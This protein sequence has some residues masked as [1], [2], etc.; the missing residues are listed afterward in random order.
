MNIKLTRYRDGW[1]RLLEYTFGLLIIGSF[2]LVPAQL[3]GQGQT[4]SGQV[5]SAD[6]G[7]VLPGVNVIVKGTNTGTS[8]DVDGQYELTV[9]SLNDTL[10]VSFVG[11]ETLEISISG[12]TEVNIEMQPQAVV[13]DEMVVIG[14]GK[15]RRS[16]VIG[17]IGSVSEQSIEQS[18][19]IVSP[20]Q[21][22]QGRI[23]GV[24]VMSSSGIP[25]QGLRI[26]IR[27]AASVSGSNEPLYVIDGV[28]INGETDSRF[29]FGIPRES[30]IAHL[31]SSDIESIE[32][33]K[34]ASA[35]AIYG[36]RATNGVVLIT[37]K[38]GSAGPTQINLSSKVGFQREPKRVDIASSDDYFEIMNKARENYNEDN[39]LALGDPGYEPPLEDPRESGE[40]DT[41]WFDLVT[42][43]NPV[44]RNFNI[45]VSGGDEKTSF[46]VSGDYMKNEG[47]IKT[48]QID[49]FSGRLNVDHQA[50]KRL[51]LNLSIGLS[52]TENNRV[53]NE[54]SGRGI[55][56]R[57]LEQ[58]PFDDPY[59]GDGSYQI[60]GVDILRHNGVQVINEQD[61]S[62]KTDDVTFNASGIFEFTE[63]L[64]YEA[65]LGGEL[66]LAHEY[67]YLNE[68]H[69]RGGS[70]GVVHDWR[71]IRRDF[72]LENM[73]RFDQDVR[74]KLNISGLLGYSMQ[75]FVHEPSRVSGED[76]PSPSFGYI[77]SAGRVSDGWTSWNSYA[78]ESWISRVNLNYDERYILSATLRRDGSSKFMDENR[79]GIFPSFSGGWR[80]AQEPFFRDSEFVS[81][82]RLRL[83]YGLT[84][85]QAGIGDYAAIPRAGAG[86]N[87]GG[88]T[89]M[90]IT[91]PGNPDLTWETANQFNAGLDLGFFDG[92]L[93]ITADYFIQNTND[94]LY[95]RPLHTTT[96]FSSTVQNIGS[97]ANRGL[98][99]EIRTVNMQGDFS[100]NTDFNISSTRN[101]VT[102]LI[103]EPVPA[104]SYHVIKEGEPLGT[105]FM[106]RQLGI[107][108][109]DDEVPQT[110][111][112]EEG[113][114]AGDI[115]YEDLN[116]DGDIT[117]ADRQVVGTANPD[118]YGGITNSFRYR[119]F[120]LSAFVSFKYGNKLYNNWSRRL[121][122]FG[123]YEY[124]LRAEH[125]DDIW[126]GP[127]T[128]NKIPRPRLG[129][130]NI[131]NSTRFLEDASYLRLQ[132]LTLGYTLP[133]D[134]TDRIQA[135]R[136]RFSIS[137]KNL[138][139][140][141]GYSGMSPEVSA[142]LNPATL[143]VDH[144]S[145]PQMRAVTFNVDLGF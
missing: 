132:N 40:E 105:F 35:T 61:A 65:K 74:E 11:Y 19:G 70:G 106:L 63:G 5:T 138:F 31:S 102:S 113:V 75:Q 120:D 4:V 24:N 136:V 123:Y 109:H 62:L 38:R 59:F 53:Q 71:T 49:R 96:G 72:L 29:S 84:G 124:A 17:S 21:A 15:Q 26:N 58:R 6:D 139:T 98:E 56:V 91:D 25:G 116:G 85:N 22:I 3:K 39:G 133:K 128:S 34:D 111:Y 47:V 107:Y 16:E 90:A 135:R 76:F 37:T 54:G 114:R 118:F 94:L 68:N 33:L 77:T 43:D 127:G 141:T 93:G 126:T 112:D 131:L 46:Y 32:I 82:L 9:P 18:T 14:Y 55:L 27:G 143:G 78:L 125:I 92:R 81:E 44:I 20:E 95:N 119:N 115:R 10:I 69:P 108:Q 48:N 42:R 137:G 12:R 140:L 7:S 134:M 100:W 67:V 45:N 121:D 144:F 1:R 79:Y 28:P 97:M 99:I 103:G 8:T 83:S 101:E 2:L 89:G 66:R 80:I 64:Q 23:S 104:G 50:S 142:S 110:L 87:Y 52:R 57:S 117:S 88:N 145:V 129:N 130:Y 41:D 86:E 36:S 13:G 73:L 30:P 51:D 60:G 122:S